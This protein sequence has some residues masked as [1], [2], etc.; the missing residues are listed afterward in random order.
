M[1]KSLGSGPACHLASHR[2]PCSLILITPYT[3]IRDCAVDLIGSFC[4]Y[5]VND[6]FRNIDLIKRVNI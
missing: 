3:S 2:N 1:G 5:L 6:K 4:K